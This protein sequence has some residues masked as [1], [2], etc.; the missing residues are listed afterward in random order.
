M[1]HLHPLAME[2]VLN[3]DQ[4][5]KLDDYED[6][7][8]VILKVLTCSDKENQLKVEQVSL[9]VGPTFVVSL[10][11]SEGDVFDPIRERLR[12]AKGRIRK[13]GSDYLAYALVDAIVDDYFVILEKTGEKILSDPFPLLGSSV[14]P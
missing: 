12:K 3:T 14:T 11:E 8:S 1:F 6:C 4:R 13:M 10:Q 5:P 2:D 7:T 9:I